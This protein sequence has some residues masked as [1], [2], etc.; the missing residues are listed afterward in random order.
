MLP[1]EQPTTEPI[2]SQLTTALANDRCI[3]NPFGKVS[4]VPEKPAVLLIARAKK[5]WSADL[6]VF[7]AGSARASGYLGTQRTALG[8]E[9]GLWGAGSPLGSALHPR[10]AAMVLWRYESGTPGTDQHSLPRKH[11]RLFKGRALWAMLRHTQKNSSRYLAKSVFPRRPVTRMGW[12]V[13]VGGEGGMELSS[14]LM[15]D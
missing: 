4:E 10:V 3:E 11:A 15:I 14:A 13:G 12:A 5:C 8:L 2:G 1:G 7:L 6:N 9:W